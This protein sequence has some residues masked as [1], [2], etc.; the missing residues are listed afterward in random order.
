MTAEMWIG[1]IN[2]A[3]LIAMYLY[4]QYREDKIT[5]RMNNTEKRISGVETNYNSKFQVVYDNQHH[6]DME[7]AQQIKETEGKLYEKI[8]EVEENIR[9]SHHKASELTH[10]ALMSI[11]IAIENLR[12][13]MPRQRR[14][15]T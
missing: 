10:K 12:G 5:E 14:R 13:R 15:I 4:I 2:A 6:S 1:G 7:R 3:T 8:S 11:N 9:E